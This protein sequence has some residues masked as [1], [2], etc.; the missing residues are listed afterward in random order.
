MVT[1]PTVLFKMAIVDFSSCFRKG[2][3]TL[4]TFVRHLVLRGVNVPV[5]FDEGGL[6]AEA[7]AAVNT[8][9]RFFPGV[10][11]LVDV[12]EGDVGEPLG[13]VVAL[14]LERL[15]RLVGSLMCAESLRRVELLPTFFTH[16]GLG[17]LVVPYMGLEG[18]AVAGLVETVPTLVLFGSLHVYLNCV[19][20]Q[21]EVGVVVKPTDPADIPRLLRVI[22]LTMNYKSLR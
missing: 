21:V 22:R 6:R 19:Q 3:A 18:T 2:L 13:T 20:L 12:E 5:V 15:D 8:L 14:V 9:E 17:H 4:A 10:D 1:N 11:P 7:L 16:A